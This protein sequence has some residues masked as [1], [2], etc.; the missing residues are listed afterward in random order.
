MKVRGHLTE[1]T[2]G[3]NK[4]LS[5]GEGGEPKKKFQRVHLSL[6]E[7]SVFSVRPGIGVYFPHIVRSSKKTVDVII[8]V[9]Q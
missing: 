9:L 3:Q 2:Q 8:Y 5:S 1:K 4:K 6:G 7:T